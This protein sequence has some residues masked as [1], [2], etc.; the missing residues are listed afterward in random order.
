MKFLILIFTQ[1]EV[2]NTANGFG[3]AGIIVDFGTKSTLKKR[4]SKEKKHIFSIIL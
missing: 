2:R 1:Q 4:P 3:H